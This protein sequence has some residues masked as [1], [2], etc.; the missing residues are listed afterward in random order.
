MAPALFAVHPEDSLAQAIRLM[1]QHQ[2]KRLVVTDAESR[3][4]GLV[5]RRAL[6]QS[7]VG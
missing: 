7:L 2:V 3:F 1:I 6:L 4:L 5:D